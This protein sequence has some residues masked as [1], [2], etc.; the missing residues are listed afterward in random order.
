MNFRAGYEKFDNSVAQQ[1]GGNPEKLTM[2]TSADYPPSE[3]RDTALQQSTMRSRQAIS[4]KDV[5]RLLS[6]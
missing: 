1:S 2:V 4:G 5:V 3:F 6:N